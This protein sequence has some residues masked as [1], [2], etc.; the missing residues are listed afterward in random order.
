MLLSERLNK[1]PQLQRPKL[2]LLPPR[3]RLRPKPERQLPRRLPMPEKLGK[4]RRQLR[5]KL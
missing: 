3:Q 5:L 1:R 2:M 4:L